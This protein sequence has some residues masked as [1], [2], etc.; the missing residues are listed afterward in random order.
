VEKL[1][2]GEVQ[3][4]CADMK[5]DWPSIDLGL[6]IFNKEDGSYVYSD[7][8]PF[9]SGSIAWI[10]YPSLPPGKYGARITGFRSPTFASF[11]FEVVEKG[12]K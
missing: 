1:T 5:T 8:A 12:N 3:W 4:I 6:K 9:S 2:G 10:I 11:D 7:Y